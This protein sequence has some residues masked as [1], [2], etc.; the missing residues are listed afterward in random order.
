MKI[1]FPDCWDGTNLTDAQADSNNSGIQASSHSH[2]TYSSNNGSMQSGCPA[3]FPV[4]LPQIVY[5]FAYPIQQTTDD[6]SHYYLSSDSDLDSNCMG[7]GQHGCS[8]HGDWMNGWE[9]SVMERLVGRRYNGTAL[10]ERAI[11]C[12]G[13]RTNHCS[14]GDIT[15]YVELTPITGA[16]DNFAERNKTLRD[17]P[18]RGFF[19]NYNP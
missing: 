13:S 16:G 4:Q 2:M 15:T 19:T 1:L 7:Y 17:R 11:S 14:E 5:Q 12:I 6:T 9:P 3:P 8:A 10:P 18:V